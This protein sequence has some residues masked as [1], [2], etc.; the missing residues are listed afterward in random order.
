MPTLRG[1]WMGAAAVLTLVVSATTVGTAHAV[2]VPCGTGSTYH[3]AAVSPALYA[4]YGASAEIEYNPPLLCGNDDIA[5]EA[6][7]SISAAWA[8]VTDANPENNG[9]RAGWA[10]SGWIK[11][12]E[13]VIFDVPVVPGTHEFL[14]YTRPCRTYVLPLT[15]STPPADKP[16]KT[17]FLGAPDTYSFYEALVEGDNYLHM[18]IDDIEYLTSNYRP[19][20]AAGNFPGWLQN[21]RTDFAGETRHPGTDMSGSLGNKTA[22]GTLAYYDA[23]V[24]RVYNGNS[25]THPATGVNEY[26]HEFFSPDGSGRR[27]SKIWTQR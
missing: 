2:G 6:G 22:F 12:G 16:V 10:Q 21:W 24:T 20:F 7:F 23:N 18:Y 5:D 3:D 25:L 26:K 11:V 1:R 19:G 9:K 14:Q 27:G 15:C 17:R 4:I 8:M 13:E